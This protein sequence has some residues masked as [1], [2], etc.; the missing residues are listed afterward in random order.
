MRSLQPEEMASPAF[1]PAIAATL[2]RFHDVPP[3]G[4]KEGHTPFGRIYKWLDVAEKFSFEE[5]QKQELFE[6]FDFAALRQEVQRVEA[7]AALAHSPLV[8]SHNDL[9]S[10]NVMVPLSAAGATKGAAEAAKQAAAAGAS[11]A[12]RQQRA[13]MTF[14]DFEYADWA[15]R[16]FDWGNH[17]CEYA[18]FECDYTR[19]PE[20]QAAELFICHYLTAMGPSSSA[21][22]GSVGVEGKQLKRCLAEANVYALAAHQYWGTWSLLQAKWSSI[23]FDY[24]SYAKLRWGEYSRRRDEFLAQAGTAFAT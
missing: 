16:G 12:A 23:D 18:G 8:F 10:G 4:D 13:V 15:P 19:Y 2:R 6:T 17:F 20:Q 7:A 21:H 22:G 11:E 9:L 24:L 5:P 1:V 3:Q 14:I